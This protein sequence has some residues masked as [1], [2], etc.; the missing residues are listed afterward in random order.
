MTTAAILPLGQ[1]VVERLQALRMFEDYIRAFE[2]LR[3]CLR[4]WYE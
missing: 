2:V 1:L 4:C 3:V